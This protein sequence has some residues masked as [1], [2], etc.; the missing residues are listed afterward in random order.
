MLILPKFGA[1]RS[2]CRAINRK[3]SSGRDGGIVATTAQWAHYR[4]HRWMP[5]RAALTEIVY[6]AVERVT[7]SSFKVET[8]GNSS[9]A[10]GF[11]DRRRRRDETREKKRAQCMHVGAKRKMPQGRAGARSWSWWSAKGRRSRI[12]VGNGNRFISMV[13]TVAEKRRAVKRSA[14]PNAV[15]HRWTN[16]NINYLRSTE[17]GTISDKT[18]I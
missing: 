11:F 16:Y 1:H 10:L 3:V 7:V 6:G 4:G 12:E 15:I 8:G 14:L 17:A 2:Q 13:L 5:N 18:S 9:M